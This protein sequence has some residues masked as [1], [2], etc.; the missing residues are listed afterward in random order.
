MSWGI[1][2]LVAAASV[3]AMAAAFAADDTPRVRLAQ[4]LQVERPDPPAN[5]AP[6]TNATPSPDAAAAANATPNAA[7][8]QTDAAAAPPPPPPRVQLFSPQGEAKQVRQA[9]ARFSVPIVALG[10]PRLEDPF[11]VT[12]GTPGTGR[13]VDP[14]NWA[15]D[16]ESDLP[17]GIRCTF[18]L[19]PALKALDGRAVA[20][21]PTF[22]F[23]TGGPAIQSSYPN[24]GWTQLDEDQ[25]FLLRLDAPATEESVRRNAYCVVD[26]IAERIP[27]EIL[28]GDA[29]TRVLD[30]RKELGYQYFNL[31]WKNGDRTGARVR[32]R[33]L[34]AAESQIATVKCARRLPNAMQVQLVW[35]RG[36][37][38]ESGIATRQAQRLSFKVRPAFMAQLTCTRTDPR[39]GCTPVQPITVQFT[40]PVPREQALA[41]RLRFPDGGVRAASVAG[42][43]EAKVVES[44]TFEAPFPESVDATL[45]LPANLRDD[46]GRTLEN[47]SRFPLAVRI[48]DYPPLVKFSGEFGILEALEGGVLPVTLRNIDPAAAGSAAVIEGRQFRV[49]NEPGA[50]IQ[51]MKKVQEAASR[52][53]EYVEVPRNANAQNG[54]DN[55]VRMRWREDT[56][57][58]S[59]FDGTE[60]TT[61]L[62]IRKPEGAKPA[63]VVGIP[64]G[65]PG[66]YVVELESRRLGNALLG[67]DAVRY[68]PTSALVTNLAI[69]LK[70]GRENSIVWVTRLDTGAPVPNAQ[71]VITNYC[72]GA[73]LWSGTTNPVGIATVEQSFGVPRSG[74]HCF[75]SFP[76][77][78]TAT[79]PSAARTAGGKAGSGE[80]D[81]TFTLSSWN[82]GIEPYSFG[83]QAEYDADATLAHSVLDRPLFRAGETVSMK[84]FLR[85]HFLRGVDVAAE[86][87]GEYSVTLSHDGSDQRYQQ[88][89]AFDADGIA[90][91]SWQIPAD[92][93]LGTYSITISRNEMHSWRSG[94]FRVEEFRLPTMRAT[95]QGTSSTLVRAREAT[96]DLHVGY[97]SG[98]GASNLPVRVRTVVEPA[99]TR[100]P[101][102][103]DYRFGG[104]AVKEGLVISEG[105]WW[106][107]GAEPEEAG[108]TAKATVLPLTLDEHGAARVTLSDL[109]EV[110]APSTLIAELEYPDP[111]GE[112]LTTS[113]RVRLAPSSLVVGIRP[114]GWVSSSELV[115]FRVVVLD[116]NGKPVA[117]QPVSVS[118]Y[119]SAS[120]SYR[121]RLIGGFYAYES[122][123]ENTKLAPGC[124]GK[125]NAQG[126]LLCSVTP[127]ASGEVLVRAEA[128]DA[129]GHCA[130][131][132]TSIWVAGTDDWWFG[133]TT[134]DRMDVLPEKQEYEAGD[135]ARFQVRM[136][137]RTARALVTVEREGVIRSFITTLSGRE[138]V[139]KVPIEKT[140]APNV[141]VSVLA[142]RGRVTSGLW[143]KVDE[144]KEVTALVDLNKP[145][146]R[147]GVAQIRVGWKPHRL[148]VKV[149]TDR[150][151]Y[152]I[153]EQANVTID[154]QRADGGSLPAGAEIAVAA[155]DEALLELAP[156][157][158]W[159]LLDSMMGERGIE[160]WTSTAQLQV[161]GKRHYGR[162]AV[163]HGGGGGRERARESFDTLLAWQGRVKLD[164]KGRATVTIPLN[165]SLTSFRIVAIANAGAS[166]FGTGMA[167]LTTKQDL[168]LLSGLP[169]VVRE[170]DEY[171]ATFT[172]RNT[173]GATI[174]V[175]LTASV[176][177]SVNVAPMQVEVPAGEARDVSWRVKAPVG[178]MS[179]TWDV[180]AKHASGGATDRLKV[181]ERVV[182][183]YPVRTYQATIERVER[184]VRIPAEIPKDAVAGRG[185]LE[186]TLRSRLGDGLDGV[187][188]YMSFYRFNCL[189]QNLSRAIALRDSGLWSAW[190]DSLPTYMDRDG[191]LRYFASELLPGED[192]LTAYVLAIA[193]EAG[194]EIPESSLSRMLS[195]LAGFVEG[196]ITRNSALPTADLTLRKLAAI[197]A[198]AR[199]GYARPDM[200]DSITI[201]P[202]LW[203]TSAVIDWLGILR[204]LESVPQRDRKRADAEAVLRARLNLQ[205]TTMT[206]S[207]E[208][209]DAL[210]WLM[211]STDSNA[212]R[213][214]LELLDRPGWREDVPRLVRGTLGRQQRGHWNTTVANA[215]GTLAMEKFSQA[216]ESTPVTGTTAV[217]YAGRS[218]RIQWPR[219]SPGET[220]FPW[221]SSPSSLSV[222]HTGGGTPW[223]IVR[224][225]A[226]LPLEA[227]LFTGYRITR[228]VTPVEQKQAGR[229]T[230]GDVA[231]VRLELEAQSDMTWVV[232]EDP[233]PGGATVLGS[234]LG[235]QSRLLTRDESAEGWVWPAYEERRF[236]VFRSYYRFVPK[237]RWVV[238]YTVRLNNPGT[239]QLPPTRVEAMYAPEMFG[240]LP[241]QPVTVEAAQ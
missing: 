107:F 238:E 52:R 7:T 50:V 206:F 93:K 16:F 73:Q 216:F 193:H 96:L 160:V 34:E 87:P 131:A 32:D 90:E 40:A 129:S 103:E 150:P 99:P 226:S 224:A 138:P 182:P 18:R 13:W 176:T 205:G 151:T 159:A 178:A 153:R 187:R 186:V 59:V 135:V 170:G 158:S 235:G 119:S 112:L 111:N 192:T 64:L 143:R 133:G 11:D 181:S 166:F 63:E 228:T 197:N 45:E 75:G 152:A 140:D 208:R 218:E 145:A 109:P 128:V 125:T 211:I 36:I 126:L 29:R 35:G 234:G 122:A 44:I 82:E 60:A 92:A 219:N 163:P 162:K 53:G 223:M 180:S 33:S 237:G 110:K 221:Q 23:N 183:V 116:L 79:A 17:A 148:D 22:T 202:N 108:A 95:V 71:V 104:D 113:G 47:A 26:G 84:H 229:W 213:A 188:E 134:A 83:M 175:E 207:T 85:R 169:P 5:A 54:D 184:P 174:P 94:S 217:N 231:R 147:L 70:W 58:R 42:D 209:S 155:V 191:L 27:I 76:L 78:V 55:G 69:H 105:S 15:Y 74:D 179:L 117:N 156:N 132:T 10:D 9:T 6:A 142:L 21:T 12:C 114:D 227:P 41:A 39:A 189:E 204:H 61:R 157:P 30:Q 65:A 185:G 101:G 199:H 195:G 127:G 212:V 31:L 241:L 24:D 86:L 236:D 203:P 62:S 146:Y 154:V 141:Y 239:F 177:P 19:K 137:F 67:R 48:D 196:R 81:F 28:T 136:P 2:Y 210:W 14:R 66:F 80:M 165:D 46:A 240:E 167:N 200:L 123:R 139:V 225:T 233:V 118:L 194:W 201:E 100:V 121:K 106:D 168:I 97:I 190:M 161:V 130:G 98:G 173:S 198:L 115:K 230:R 38:T 37:S 171:A 214:L 72:S 149:S 4:A 102:Y 91:Q 172:V 222:E 20:G 144:T 68:V 8:A 215:W 120:Y 220:A 57:D 124:T 3:A 43:R 49:P 51:W 164:E 89:V 77:L 56:G 88:R 232:G 1:R 25:V